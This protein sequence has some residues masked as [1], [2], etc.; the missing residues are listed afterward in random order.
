MNRKQF[1]QIAGPAFLLLANGQLVQ[2]T[3]L[4]SLV[5]KRKKKIRFV[6]AS[7]GH[8]GEKNTDYVN[9]FNTLVTRINEEHKKERFDFCMINGDIVHNDPAFYPDAKAVLDQLA[10]RYY[11]TLGNHDRVSGEQWAGIWNMPLNYD[12]VIGDTAF[13]AAA[14]SDISGKYQS[15]DL[16]WF[17]QKFEQHKK[18]KN[19]FVFFHIHDED[20]IKTWQ[21]LRFVFDAHFGGSWGTTYRGFRVVELLK[22][23]SVLTYILNPFDKINPAKL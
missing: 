4:L 8:Y 21:N 20:G 16:G 5:A 2:A 7:D 15:P 19:L 10:P 13:L 11:V 6:I 23:N 12:F 17:S 1:L 22:D 18:K 14:T 3:D 9:F